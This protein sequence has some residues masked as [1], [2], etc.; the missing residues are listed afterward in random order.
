[1]SSTNPYPFV[2]LQPAPCIPRPREHSHSARARTAWRARLT[3]HAP[4]CARAGTLEGLQR[5]YAGPPP[6]EAARDGLLLL[7]REALYEAGAS[8]LLLTWADA[9]CS[10][11]FYDYGS[12]RMDEA[13]RRSPEKAERWRTAECDAAVTFE[14]LAG[15]V[16][17]LEAEA[18]LETEPEPTAVH[19]A[20]DASMDD[21]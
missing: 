14:E 19:A 5:A 21:Q 9:T 7:H 10:A 17:Q 18:P 4:A 2:P 15:H 13:V 20:E 8:P 6:F 16:A 11:R 1:M 3:R 12:A